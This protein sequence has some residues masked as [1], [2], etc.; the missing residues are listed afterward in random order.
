MKKIII[1]LIVLFIALAFADLFTALASAEHENQTITTT[2]PIVVEQTI[3]IS[4]AVFSGWNMLGFSLYPRVVNDSIVSSGYDKIMLASLENRMFYYNES[5]YSLVDSFRIGEGFWM[6]ATNN[7]VLVQVGIP[8]E[9]RI[10]ILSNGWNMVSPLEKNIHPQ[11]LLYSHPSINSIWGFDT[12][13]YRYRD[14]IFEQS[15]MMPGVG[16]WIKNVG[17]D[18]LFYDGFSADV[19]PQLPAGKL[20]I[21]QSKEQPP[22]APANVEMKTWGGVKRIFN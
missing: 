9:Q 21:Q 2:P 15:F 17:I 14:I 12:G 1:V 18:T 10:H 19:P 7:G 6:K 13:E 16:Y 4:P 22:P 11:N 3:T 8:F 5:G 20:L